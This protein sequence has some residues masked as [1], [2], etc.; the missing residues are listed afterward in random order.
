MRVYTILYGGGKP[1]KVLGAIL[2]ELG[3]IGEQQHQLAP[4]GLQLLAQLGNVFQGVVGGLLPRAQHS[5]HKVAA[6]AGLQYAGSF[7]RNLSILYSIRTQP[8]SIR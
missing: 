5:Y 4:P 1:G 7:V 2:P 3:L 6:T 8:H